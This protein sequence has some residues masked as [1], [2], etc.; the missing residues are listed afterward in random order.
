M[1]WNAEAAGWLPEG[2]ARRMFVA[3]R[4][5]VLAGLAPG[6]VRIEINPFL[7]PLAPVLHELV[8]PLRVVHLV[9]DPRDWIRSM[10]NFGAAGWRRHVIEFVPFA[11][12]VHP[13]ARSR[14][15]SLDT[16]SRFAW[17]WRLANE[18]LRAS[19]AH[20]EHYCLIRYEDL[21]SEERSLAQATARRLFD[22]MPPRDS[23]GE[24]DANRERRVNPSRGGKVGP[25]QHWPRETQQR[26]MEICAPLLAPMG[27]A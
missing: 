20:A 5:R 22:S 7:H 25:W 3:N 12:T 6:R 10:A 18:Q 8:R 19:G 27:Y 17:R 23:G 11:R 24:L 4:R 2:A 1:V 21:F 26:V 9:R 13:E 14:W 15:R 16:I